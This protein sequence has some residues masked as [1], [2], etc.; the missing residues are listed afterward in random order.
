MYNYYS[1]PIEVLIVEDE[2]LY[3]KVIKDFL[4]E[5]S[6]FQVVGDAKDGQTAVCLAKELRPDVVIMD[7]RLPVMSG[8]EATKKIK[9]TNPYIKVIALTARSDKNEAIESLEAGASAYVNKEIDMQQFKMIIQTIN[10]GAVWLDPVIGYKIFPEIIK[11]LYR[12]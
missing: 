7:L 6:G 9:K 3:K 1:L 4:Q 12:N 8:I 10:N 11:S 5:D 2:N